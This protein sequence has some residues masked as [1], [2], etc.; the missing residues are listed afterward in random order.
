MRVA[1]R[2]PP[3]D[4]ASNT[5]GAKPAL[6]EGID[7]TALRT[8]AI[9]AALAT[10]AVAHAD[11]RVAYFPVQPGA[12]PLD[13]AAAPDGN[14][15]FTAPKQGAMGVLDPEAGKVDSVKARTKAMPRRR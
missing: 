6:I 11:T 13:V 5:T 9:C 3:N 15:W 8:A 12:H 14:I 2:R 4:D 7:E 1:N 10:Y